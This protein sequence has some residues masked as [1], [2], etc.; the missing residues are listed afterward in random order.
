MST[1][2]HAAEVFT[3]GGIIA[4]PTE[5]VFGL[6]CDPDNDKAVRKLLSLKQRSVDKGLILLAAN[7]SQLLPYLNDDAINQEKR[8]SILSRWPDAITQVLPAKRNISPLLCGAFDSIAVRI[9][10]H[11]DVVALCKLTNKAIVSTSANLAGQP[12]ATT[13]QQVEQQLGDKVDCIIKADT[14]GFLKPTSIINGLTG[15]IIRQ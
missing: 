3:Q 1:I 14:L 7:Y 5:A 4:Y 6:G 12:P 10:N 8:F 13:W 2:E 15:D 9:T 11:P